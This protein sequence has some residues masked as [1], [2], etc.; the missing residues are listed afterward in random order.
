VQ[1]TC[2]AFVTLTTRRD[3][4]TVA[5]GM[6]SYREDLWVCDA[7][8]EPTEVLWNNVSWRGWERG[9]RGLLAWGIFITLIVFMI[10][11]ITAITQLFNISAYAQKEGA[12][13]A[14]ARWILSIPVIDS[15]PRQCS[16]VLLHRYSAS[17]C[18]RIWPHHM[19]DRSWRVCD[20]TKAA[21]SQPQVAPTLHALRM[22]VTRAD[23]SCRGRQPQ[24]GA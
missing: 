24:H 21:M 5:T 10:P 4:A 17:S 6:L 16:P 23:R 8:P 11:I 19:G 18:N 22:M 13:G 12:A 2:A 3:Q 20:A 15:A 14:W 1:E 7:A 9:I